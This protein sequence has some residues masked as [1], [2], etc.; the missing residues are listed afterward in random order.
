M[1]LD[2]YLRAD[3]PS[4]EIVVASVSEAYDAAMAL[5]GVGRVLR[6]Q[7]MRTA[8]SLFDEVSA[9]L[10]FPPYFGENWDALEEC[11]ADLEW[12]H[13][14]DCVLVI[15]NAANVLDRDS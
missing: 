6:G 8:E 14:R 1:K 12:L 5:P 9:A 10:Q 15:L 11:L 4:L 7:K 3:G 2:R 13:T